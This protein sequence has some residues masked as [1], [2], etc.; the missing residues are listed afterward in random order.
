MNKSIVD[1]FV[2]MIERGCKD[3]D[4]LADALMCFI[5]TESHL[6]LIPEISSRLPAAQFTSDYW[7][8]KVRRV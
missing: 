4:I 6:N 1:F 5:E 8:I 7:S 2:N 3:E